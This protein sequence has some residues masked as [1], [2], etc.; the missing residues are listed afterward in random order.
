MASYLELS[1]DAR[2]ALVDGL[3][4]S[5]FDLRKASARKRRTKARRAKKK[6]PMTF[7]SPELEKIFN[8]MPEASRRLVAG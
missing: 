6:E 7:S 5:R 3:R 1:D 2:L 8:S 4:K